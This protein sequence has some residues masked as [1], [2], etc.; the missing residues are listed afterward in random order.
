MV[1]ALFHHAFG[2]GLVVNT[3]MFLS[4]RIVETR[5]LGAG[6]CLPLA[7]FN[8]CTLSNRKL[9]GPGPLPKG[10]PGFMSLPRNL[11]FSLF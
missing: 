1:S 2:V 8:R 5:R 6:T 4:R 9:A 11:F 3:M 7:P 10:S